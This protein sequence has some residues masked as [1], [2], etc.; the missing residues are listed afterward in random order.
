MIRELTPEEFQET[1][2]ENMRLL[3]DDDDTCVNIPLVSYVEECI[4]VHDMQVDVDDV[5]FHY[6]YMNDVKKMCHVGLNFGD[7]H[8]Y[9]VVVVD[10]AAGKILGHTV[11]D[12]TRLND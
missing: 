12:L 10:V 6:A 9:L 3:P 2:C 5:E 7:A 11:L 1:I 8:L 4:G